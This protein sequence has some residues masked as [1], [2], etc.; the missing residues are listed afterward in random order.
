MVDKLLFAHWKLD[1]C[2]FVWIDD[3][4][5]WGELES[6]D[7]EDVG[8]VVIVGS[9]RIAKG[10]AFE[11]DLREAQV[12]HGSVL[13]SL[14]AWMAGGCGYGLAWFRR[15]IFEASLA[16]RPDKVHGFEW[17]AGILLLRDLVE[18]DRAH[19]AQAVAEDL[20]A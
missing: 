15:L 9:G 11:I 7:V 14:L 18:V 16:K 4:H 6:V 3:G 1:L 10:C 13:T 5:G 2:L 12:A 17:L 20:Q 19:V 8:K